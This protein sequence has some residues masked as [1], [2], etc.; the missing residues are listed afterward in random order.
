MR[1]TGYSALG[2][3]LTTSSFSPVT[4]GVLSSRLKR[5]YKRQQ[6]SFFS[7]EEATILVMRTMCFCT[8]VASEN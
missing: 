2:R 8:A 3:F 5:C 6:F 7:R 1:L 4:A